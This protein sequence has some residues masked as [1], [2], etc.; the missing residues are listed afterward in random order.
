MT[1]EYVPPEAEITEFGTDDVI[2][3]STENPMPWIPL[4]Q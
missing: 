2:V 1:K 3:T 4:N